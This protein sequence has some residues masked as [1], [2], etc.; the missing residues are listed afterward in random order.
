LTLAQGG[1]VDQEH[2]HG[3]APGY[4]PGGALRAPQELGL[5]LRRAHGARV[6][7]DEGTALGAA[8]DELAV[9]T[10]R[11]LQRVDGPAR[12]VQGALGEA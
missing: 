4:L 10:G 2:G 5:E 9:G 11:A 3:A 7:G 12:C 6:E 8:D 1:V